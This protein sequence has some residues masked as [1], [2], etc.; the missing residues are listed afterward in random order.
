MYLDRGIKRLLHEN[1]LY[2]IRNL[3]VPITKRVL[4]AT[5][6]RHS[7]PLNLHESEG[8]G[9]IES[10]RDGWGCARYTELHEGD[11]LGVVDFSH[12]R[13]LSLDCELRGLKPNLHRVDCG[14]IPSRLKPV[15][16]PNYPVP[17]AEGKVPF[18]EILGIGVI[19]RHRDCDFIEGRPERKVLIFDIDIVLRREDQPN[20]IWCSLLRT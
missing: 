13:W 12:K 3:P 8:S 19:W 4:V 9:N 14:L 10:P 20:P 5:E 16:I 7:Q 2:T 1:R 15:N 17:L 6:E 11:K 18:E